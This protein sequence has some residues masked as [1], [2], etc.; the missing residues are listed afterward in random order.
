MK[1]IALFLVFLFFVIS[2]PGSVGVGNLSLI[3]EASAE[4]TEDDA[5]P[6]VMEDGDT[7]MED[8]EYNE[9]EEAEPPPVEF[10]EPPDT[11]VAP[12]GTSYVNAYVQ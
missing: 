11:A 9:Q 4:I 5:P 6:P 3:K 1:Q 12:G 10:A 7:P 2:L 8:E